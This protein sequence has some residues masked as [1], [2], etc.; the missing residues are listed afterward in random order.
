MTY[1]DEIADGYDELHRDEQL[2]KY[3]AL[4]NLDLIHPED[5]L[6]DLGHGSGLIST[7]FENPITGVDSSEALLARS[8]CET[9]VFDFNDPLPFEDASFDWVVSF[10]ALH[11]AR[12]PALLIAQAQRI[13]RRGVAI[14][15]L[16]A[17]P[18]A[19]RIASLLPDWTA[20]PAG[21]DTLYV[22][23]RRAKPL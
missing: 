17:L 5:T 3:R 2:E 12:D 8:P 9:I 14:S 13:A 19:P 1:Y 11:H 20:L 7:V 23:S 15:L 16:R 4:K 21:A 22:W 18:S 6:L 10:T